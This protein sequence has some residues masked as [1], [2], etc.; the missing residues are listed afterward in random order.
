MPRPL[1]RTL[2]ALLYTFA[3]LILLWLALIK[4]PMIYT[5]WSVSQLLADFHSIRASQSTWAD[6]QHLMARWG[7]YG[8]YDGTCTAVDCTYD[9]GISDPYPRWVNTLPER[10][11]N[12]IYAAH[13]P[14]LASRI[15]WRWTYFAVQFTVQDAKIV[16][17]RTALILA[18]DDSGPPNHWSY[19][20]GIRTQVRPHLYSRALSTE[21]DSPWIVGNDEQLEL[22][23]DYK[24]GRP[25]GCMNCEFDEITYTSTL[26]Q[27]EVIRL[28]D[29]NL[30]CI[31]R[32]HQCTTIGDLLPNGRD[33]RLYE[34]GPSSLYPSS[35]HG[36]IPCGTD[37]RALGRDASVIIEVEPLTTGY[38]SEPMSYN[39]PEIFEEYQVRLLRILKG[40]LEKSPGDTLKI[41]PFYG[42][43][44]Q[45]QLPDELPE[46][47]M[48][49]KR[50]F[51]LVPSS[52]IDPDYG[53]AAMRCG[54]LDDTP[55]NL[56]ALQAG[57]AQDVS[58]RRPITPIPWP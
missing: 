20:L 16:H 45:R 56:A 40:H 32:F 10:W 19:L 21:N 51:V 38:H 29:Y 42:E 25:G 14:Q 23:P 48:P 12:R 15:G 13:L 54:I 4:A 57:I 36:P 39:P 35:Q 11:V 58:Y 24:V 30:S 28:T 2:R 8:H 34:D 44:N 31:T 9:I 22:H 50:A 53:L 1:A 55:A 47:L 52:Y 43:E 18:V 3:T 37:P 41:S 27:E 26:P 17:D 5:R 46:H 7:K 49:G 33:W 6:A